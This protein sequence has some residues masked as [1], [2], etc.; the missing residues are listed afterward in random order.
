MNL[1]QRSVGPIWLKECPLGKIVQ[2]Q[3]MLTVSRGSAV[4]LVGL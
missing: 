4:S 1:S 3:V 2:S